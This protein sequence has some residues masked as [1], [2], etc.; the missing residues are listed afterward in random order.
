MRS[1]AALLL[2]VLGLS[3]CTVTPEGRLLKWEERI[4]RLESEVQAL[5]AKLDAPQVNASQKS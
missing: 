5:K 3:G 2:V 1:I 4:L